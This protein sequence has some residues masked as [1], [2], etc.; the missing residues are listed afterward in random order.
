MDIDRL[1]EKAQSATPGP[2]KS[3]AVD[4]WELD[5]EEVDQAGVDTP[6]G[7]L[8]WD[9]HGG[10]VFKP[11]DA[12]FIAAA[13]PKAIMK[14]IDTLR[15]SRENEVQCSGMCLTGADVGVYGNGIAYPHKSC[16]KHGDPVAYGISGDMLLDEFRERIA[17]LEAEVASLQGQ[18]EEE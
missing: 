14:L 7:S 5:D 13:N 2:W 18:Q 6:S 17:E 8:T 4:Q 16:P 1:Y 11:E 15:E 12:R 3:T 10:E 9:D